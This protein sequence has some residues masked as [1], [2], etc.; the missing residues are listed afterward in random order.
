MGSLA[1]WGGWGRQRSAWIGKVEAVVREGI[2]GEERGTRVRSIV[3][4]KWPAH[5][6]GGG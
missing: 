2:G 4:R 5:G 3:A 1:A 6:R